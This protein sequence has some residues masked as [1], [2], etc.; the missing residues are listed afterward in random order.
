MF[1]VHHL[2]LSNLS[3]LPCRKLTLRSTVCLELLTWVVS[4]EIPLS[5]LEYQRWYKYG[6]FPELYVW[7]LHYR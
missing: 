3:G 5:A 2:G 4:C 7:G 1:R 6:V